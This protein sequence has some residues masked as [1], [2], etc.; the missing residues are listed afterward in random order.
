MV[1]YEMTKDKSVG[2]VMEIS[3]QSD[4]GADRENTG[5]SEKLL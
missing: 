5:D 1:Q 3:Q 4:A 2:H